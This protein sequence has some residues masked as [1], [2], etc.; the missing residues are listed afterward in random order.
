M[1]KIINLEDLFNN[2]FDC[3]TE[4]LIDWRIQDEEPAMTKDVFKTVLFFE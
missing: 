4:Q 2:N 3:Y 1:E